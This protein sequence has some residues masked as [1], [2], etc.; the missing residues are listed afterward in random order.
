MRVAQEIQDSLAEQS[1]LGYA[2]TISIGFAKKEYAQTSIEELHKRAEDD[3]IR[4][5]FVENQSARLKMV[6]LLLQSLFKK[7][8]RE[9]EHSKRIG[10]LA[11]RFGIYLGL[12]KDEVESLYTVGIMHDIGKIAITTKILNKQSN[13]D[14][15]EW[16]DFQRHPEIGF[17]ILS[18]VHQYAPIAEQVLC[19]HE[20]WDGKGYPNQIAGDLIPY[21]SRILALCEA[22]DAMTTYRPY[23]K[24]VSVQE[25]LKEIRLCSNTHYDPHLAGQFIAMLQKEG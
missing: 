9:M 12:E 20:R 19:H 21:F 4:N 3:L 22:F 1:F 14:D 24:T 2:L 11:K 13:L 25:A 16:K 6:D 15:E 5:K 23:R 10:L 7:S 8:T 17:N 18:S